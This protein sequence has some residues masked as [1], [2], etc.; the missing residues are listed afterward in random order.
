[1]DL[2]KNSSITVN[3]KRNAKKIA[4]IFEY[5]LTRHHNNRLI[6]CTSIN[7]LRN[8]NIVGGGILS[9]K[10]WLHD[11]LIGIVFISGSYSTEYFKLI[12]ILLYYS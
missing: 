3:S 11:Y 2:R 1:M 6:I 9:P 8:S 10:C 7:V 5:P 12:I 4:R